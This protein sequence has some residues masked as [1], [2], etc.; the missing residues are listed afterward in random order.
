MASAAASPE[1]VNGEPDQMAVSTAQA[2]DPDGPPVPRGAQEI[3][4]GVEPV[5]SISEA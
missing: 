1:E 5:F 4:K 2:V 3:S